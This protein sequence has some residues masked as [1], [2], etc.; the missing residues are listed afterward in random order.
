MKEK[1]NIKNIV[2]KDSFNNWMVSE[3]KKKQLNVVS[4]VVTYKKNPHQFLLVN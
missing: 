3:I 1:F 4:R 2:I